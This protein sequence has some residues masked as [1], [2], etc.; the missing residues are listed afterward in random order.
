MDL[1]ENKNITPML[2]GMESEP[3]DDEDFLFEL[4]LDGERCLAYLDPQHGTE[5]RNKRHKPMLPVVPELA[6]LHQQVRKKCILDG[7]LIVIKDQVPCFSEIQRRSLMTNKIKIEFAAAQYPASFVAYD[8]LYED[9]QAITE[10]P[11]LERKKRLQKV[12]G[13]ESQRLA[14]SRYIENQGKQL[15]LLTEE[16]NL[17]GV[18]AKRKNSFYYLNKTTKDWMKIKNLQDDDFVVCGYIPKSHYIVSIVL[19]QYQEEDLVYKGHVTM[20]ISRDDFAVIERHPKRSATPFLNLPKGRGNEEAIWLEP[21]LVCTVK[22]MQKT[23][24]GGLRQ[25]VFKGLRFDKSA[26][27]C[28]V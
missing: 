20:G 22:Y 25:P 8:I 26:E 28:T 3:F 14:I 10:L 2:I 4:K 5:L 23:A 11:L 12:V 1:F 9:E 19:G 17:E 6:E 16:K 27:E 21:D 13:E 18:I 24:E 15:Y 7:E